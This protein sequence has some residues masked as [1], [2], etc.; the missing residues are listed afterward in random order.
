MNSKLQHYIQLA[1]LS[2]VVIGCFQI[3]QPFIPALLFAAV[4]CSASWPLHLRL[5]SRLNGRATVSAAVMTLLL[6]VLVIGPSSL[7]AMSLADD[8]THA[9]ERVRL[10]LD[11]GPMPPPAWLRELPLVGVPL[12][13]Y[14]HRIADSREEF[15][16][17]LK[18]LI[19]PTKTVL[20]VAGRAVAGSLIQMLFAAF[21]LFFFYRDGEKLVASARAMLGT[22]AGGHG[23]EILDTVHHTVTGVVHGIFGTALA[24]GL[25]AL[26]G[27]WVAGV[28][29]ALVLAA[30]TFFLSMIP[31]GPPLI[32]GGATIW[33]FQQEQPGWGVFMLLWGLLAI[34]SIDN[35]VKPLLISRHSALPMLLIV[36]GVFGGIA[37]FGFIG[38]FIGPPMLAVGLNLVQM[39][40][41]RPAAGATAASSTAAP[42]QG[43]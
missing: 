8:V 38:I 32:W 30:A 7:L 20:L 37:A 1:A 25:V 3:L 19:E 12:D 16:A 17:L 23:D 24:Q 31:V 35:V 33:L 39:W 10:L 2:V 40:T 26:A 4:A 27:F 15:V 13:N 41:A 43:L 28:P 11:A 5:R 14:W 29:G 18:S 6:V 22:L 9:V 21:V 42:D 36:L 34:S